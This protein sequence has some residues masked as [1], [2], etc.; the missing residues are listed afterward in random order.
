MKDSEIIRRCIKKNKKAW[1]LFIQKYSRLI[2]WAITKRLSISGFKLNQADI[3]DI[4]QEVLLTILKGDKLLQL[5]DIKF[6]PGWL[7]MVASNKTVD[8]MR[9]KEYR[10]QNLIV[11]I[12]EFKDYSFE[13]E[14]LTRDKITVIK[15]I[16]DTLPDKEKII[17]CLN[18]LEEK[19]HKEIA[20]IM[21]MPINTVSTI[22]ARTKE[23]I[24]KKLEKT[25]SGYVF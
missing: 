9:D 24:K 18:I 17:I 15:N 11:D 22:V 6:L 12:P 2:Y 13:Q 14:L 16:I 5:K 8:Y 4:F 25:D 1:V 19:T 3:E 7:S 20:Q 23:K 10:K 21:G